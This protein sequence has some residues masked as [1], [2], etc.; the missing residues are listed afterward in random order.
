MT[1]T[2][3]TLQ[4]KQRLFRTLSAEHISTINPLEIEEANLIHYVHS[5]IDSLPISDARLTQL[6]QET[7]SDPILQQL[8]KFTLNGW[9]QRHEIPHT[10][11]LYY[12][13][14]GEIVYNEGLLLKGQRIIIPSSLRNTMKEIIHQGHNGIARCINRARQ[15][16]Y[17]PGMNAEIDDLVSPC[18]H[19]LTY[20]NK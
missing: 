2:S 10:V 20:R 11:K 1:L 5:I 19:C 13:L 9:P 16:I 8:K 17:W 3:N 6:Q 15:S 12:N 4:A 18:T 14:R 7:A